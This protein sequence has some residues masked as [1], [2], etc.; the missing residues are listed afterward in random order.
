MAVT[1]PIFVGLVIGD[2]GYGLLLL[3]LGAWLG[4]RA[5]S[6]RAWNINFLSMR[7]PVQLLADLSFLLKVLA[8]WI[9]LFGIIYAEFFGT[10]PALLFHISPLYDRVRESQ[11]SQNYF[12]LGIVAGIF[13]IFLGLF[14]HLIQSIRHKHALGVFESIVLILGTAGLLLFLGGQG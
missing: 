2:I 12:I 13:M 7:F 10:L 4:G 6:G 3:L 11:E 8:F 5:K 14:V 1:F 9:I